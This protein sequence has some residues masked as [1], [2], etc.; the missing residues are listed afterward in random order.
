MKQ[1]ATLFLT[2]V[3]YSAITVSGLMVAGIATVM[4]LA[5]GTGEDITG[6]VAPALLITIVSSIVAIVA[7][8]FQ[9]REP[10]TVDMKRNNDLTA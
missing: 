4:F 9:N 3:K 7:S 1:D 10:K 2:M 8:V 5:R 6:V